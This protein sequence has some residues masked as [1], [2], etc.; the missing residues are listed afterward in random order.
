VAFVVAGSYRIEW[1]AGD[2]AAKQSLILR[3]GEG[4]I[5]RE[6]SDIGLVLARPLPSDSTA[7]SKPWL[8]L[9]KLESIIDSS[10]AIVP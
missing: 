2:S 4:V 3:A 7:G 9:I 8:T 6:V 5:L 10:A 1:S